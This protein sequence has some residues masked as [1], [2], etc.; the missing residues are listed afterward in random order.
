MHIKITSKY[1]NIKNVH[2]NME[3]IALEL[4]S[5]VLYWCKT[6]ALK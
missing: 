5:S 2:L 4:Y 3:T 1:K 6:S